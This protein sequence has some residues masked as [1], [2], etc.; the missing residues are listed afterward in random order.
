[1]K[2]SGMKRTLSA[3]LAA[4]ALMALLTTPALAGKPLVQTFEESD[5]FTISCGTVTL[6]EE[7]TQS[8]VVTRWLDANGDMTRGHARVR[9][10]GTIT[11]PGSELRLSE[12]SRFTSFIDF[13]ADGPTIREIGLQYKFSAPGLGVVG[14]DVGVLAFLPNGDVE[15]RGPHDVHEN[16]V[17]PVICP[18]FE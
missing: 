3:A 9:F 4:L 17:M 8:F 16:G 11:G 18:L 1:M 13:G 14:H 10:D 15:V 12:Q 2:E 7:Y 5:S 6:V